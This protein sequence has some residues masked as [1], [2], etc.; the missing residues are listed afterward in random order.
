MKGHR[1]VTLCM[2][3]LLLCASV[4]PAGSSS[5]GLES[6][7]QAV[8]RGNYPEA[9]AYL[10]ALPP[11]SLSLQE[12]HRAR[13]LYGHVALRLKRYPEALQAFGDVVGHYPELGD[14]ALWNVARIHQELNTE[15]LYVE[16][17][18]LLLSRYPQS[19]LVP[20][21][22]L[23]LG[24]QLI[25]VNGELIE[26]ARILEELVAHQ[27][28][29]AAA[30]EAYLWLGQGYEGVG[31]RDKAAA[32]YR[33]VYVRFP[34]SPEVERA[35]FRLETLLPPGRLLA[36]ALSPRERLERADQLAEGGDCDRAMYEVRQLPAVELSGDL[37]A[38]AARRLGFCAY[39]LRR[40]REA[41]ANLEQ[42]RD[43]RS[44]DERSAEAL[45]IFGVALQR[46][47][48]TAEAERTLRQ[49]AAREPQTVW[50]GKALVTLG[51]SYESRQDLERAGETYR[52]LVMRFPATD[53]ADELAWR[54][55]WLQYSQRQF[56]SAARE[57]GAAAE[58]F[59]QS[60]FASNARFWQAKALEK[61]G[62]GSQALP[63]YEQVAREYP[64]TYY[65]LR[66]QEVLRTR[67]PLGQVSGNALPLG[68][69]FVSS[70]G[71]FQQSTAEAGLSD[72]AR[73]HGVRANELLALR[74]LDDGREEIAHWAKGLG[75]GVPER[76]LLARA[77]LKADMPPQAI[78]I[79]NTA[80]SSVTA[81]E[82]LSLPSEFWTSL[83][84]MLYWEEVQD[85]ARY[86]PLDPWLILGVIRQESAFSPRAVSRSDAR[87]LMQ[88]LPST[89]REV[90]ERIG[91]AAFRDDLLF[92]PRLNVRLGAQYL[93]RLTEA[94][95]G[96]L[97]LALAAYN[98]GPGRVKRW[99]QELSTA[100]WD[101]FIEHLPFEETRLYVKSVLRNHGV[102]QRLYALT[103]AAQ[104][105]R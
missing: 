3:V 22:R 88:L 40:Y 60:M 23:A 77:Y 38:W 53:R 46:D 37:G 70:T 86:T 91:L 63:L 96:N 82:R 36:T 71:R 42:F 66:A 18:R 101:E 11:A 105:A 75:E 72:A 50:N 21:V 81:V 73:F 28:K 85:A 16:T 102:Y 2:I 69:N 98:A 31:Q 62:H 43:H 12:R 58:R 29:D 83:F 95:R 44:A 99:I 56:S 32:A 33:A 39:R 49:L 1:G 41:I 90:Y 35:A 6:V 80:L 104:M 47:G 48:Q 103:P 19:R 52:E 25:G 55:G 26:G 93:G 65:G 92:D 8:E 45:Y 84:P 27:S 100:D 15:R 76:A 17:L 59:P 7:V 20:Q 51:L 68:G 57:F 24:R 61:S 78:R 5:L 13:Y 54:I 30:P 64:Y 74:F 67:S 89:G 10:T 4:P 79:L 94:H 34:M 9:L 87:G 97:I 14:Y